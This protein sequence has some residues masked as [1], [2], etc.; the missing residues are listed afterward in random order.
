M[1]GV[2]AAFG[3]FLPVALAVALGPFPIIA[4]VL[5][6]AQP[7]GVAAGVGLL[8]GWAA[9]LS[10]LSLVLT[11]AV[12]ELD[13]FGLPNGG[14]W[15]RVVIGL[16]LVAAAVAKWRRRPR[17]TAEP[18]VPGWIRPLEAAEPARAALFGL[19]LGASPKNVALTAAAAAGIAYRGLSGPLALV[20]VTLYVALASSSMI[21]ALL[22]RALGGQSAAER[23][24]GVKAFMLRH[25][26]VVM[27]VVFLF[28]GLKILGDGLGELGS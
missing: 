23:L 27:M 20:A 4:A 2:V 13:G 17:G 21:V 7:A 9:S 1:N 19:V 12:G 25:N 15:L 5:V 26:A 3:D 6:L 11:F 22:A 14:A 16:L 8:A 28:L 18:P 24:E 10:V